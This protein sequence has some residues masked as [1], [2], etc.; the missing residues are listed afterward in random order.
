MWAL[1]K[2]GA[3]ERVYGFPKALTLNGVQHPEN[4]FM[5]WTHDEKKAIG[6]YECVEEGASPDSRF[7][8]LGN[9]VTTVDDGAGVVK[10]TYS[11]TAKE[12]G[13]ISNLNADGTPAVDRDGKPSITKGLKTRAKE[14]V[15]IISGSLLAPTDWYVIRA[16]EGGVATPSNVTTYRA[17]VRTKSNDMEAAIDAAADL[18]AFIALHNNTND[19]D[20]KL[21]ATAI[22]HDWPKAP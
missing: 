10:K 14:Q 13:D 11:K 19:A 7:Y 2:N 4:I 20:G 21:V 12:L 17:A 18:D 22:L 6:I 1:V 3:V 15:K 9:S 8:H 5:N 16:A